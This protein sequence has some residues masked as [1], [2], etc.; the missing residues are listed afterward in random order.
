MDKEIKQQIGHLSRMLEAQSYFSSK[1]KHGKQ[2]NKDEALQHLKTFLRSADV[3]RQDLTSLFSEHRDTLWEI[4]SMLFNRYNDIAFKFS[5]ED[6][7]NE[8]NLN[9]MND[10]YE[11]VD[12][13][14]RQKGII[15]GQSMTFVSAILSA[16]LGNT[17]VVKDRLLKCL[18]FTSLKNVKFKDVL[19]AIVKRYR[20]NKSFYDSMVSKVIIWATRSFIDYYLFDRILLLLQM[21]TQQQLEDLLRLYVISPC[22]EI[23]LQKLEE[24]LNKTT[25]N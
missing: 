20:K 17:P 2:L 14:L 8:E 5:F 7:E 11:Y 19:R 3:R 1:A 24:Y 9:K 6:L 15:K 12:N 10:A 25:K 21:I 13:L 22:T 16:V 18:N 23:I 4:V